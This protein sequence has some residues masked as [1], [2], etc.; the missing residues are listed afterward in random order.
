MDTII[1]RGYTTLQCDIKLDDQRREISLLSVANHFTKEW[2]NSNKIGLRHNYLLSSEK[3]KAEREN[4]EIIRV[5]QD[6]DKT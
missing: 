6:R 5:N 3:E 2:I 4:D 1:K